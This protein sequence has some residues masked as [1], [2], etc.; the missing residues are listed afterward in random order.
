M[1]KVITN[2]VVCYTNEGFTADRVNAPFALVIPKT[3]L[4]DQTP[5]QF[6]VY[7]DGFTL[8]TNANY[9]GWRFGVL[10]GELMP[11]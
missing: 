7:F 5:T 8:S 9:E 2:Y 3:N 10:R 6:K 4:M 1:T 11:Q